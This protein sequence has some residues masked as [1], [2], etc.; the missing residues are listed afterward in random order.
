MLV[1]LH[2][3]ALP[4]AWGV[5]ATRA[6]A[7]ADAARRAA[8]PVDQY[9]VIERADVTIPVDCPAL[10]EA[11][12]QTAPADEEELDARAGQY[13]ADFRARWAA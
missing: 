4:R 10:L 12:P 1:I 8:L 11:V 5:G 6:E 3:N 13:D 2:K 7:L 9:V